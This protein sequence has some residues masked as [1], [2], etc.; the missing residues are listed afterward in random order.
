MCDMTDCG[1]SP[2]QNS[3][4]MGIRIPDVGICD[5]QLLFN[6][7]DAVVFTDREVVIY[8]N[9]A[10]MKLI[11]VDSEEFI[12]G[13][14]LTDFIHPSQHHHLKSRIEQVYE[15]DEPVTYSDV[16]IMNGKGKQFIAEISSIRIRELTGNVIMLNVVRDITRRKQAED[17]LV[18][19]EKLSVIG[20]L[21]AGVAHE[22]RNPLAALKGFTQ[23][24]KSKL[25]D[26]SSYFNIM[27]SEIDRINLIVN[28]FMTLAKPKYSDY[29]VGKLEPI[30]QSVLSILETQ[31]T[32]LNIVL[33]VELDPQLP[34]V[35]CSENEL[36]QVFLNIIKNAL[37]SMPEGGEVFIKGEVWDYDTVGIS[38]KDGGQGIPEELI[39]KL[40][41]PFV[42]TKEKGTGLGLMISSRIIE[43]HK[44]TL[45]IASSLNNGTTVTIKLPVYKM[46]QLT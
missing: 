12:V 24:L 43:Q 29:N 4:E 13:K 25:P 17:L 7:P 11:D 35:L 22:I 42:T 3:L 44:G 31:A 5:Q 41:E 45:N 19:S 2:E 36:K 27:A 37:E 18:R 14:P 23:L 8:V 9:K 40:G 16:I 20:Q 34:H 39:P 6:F 15:S 21:A 32:L 38:I 33:K 28:E 26:Y 46:E 1:Y 10:S 30:I